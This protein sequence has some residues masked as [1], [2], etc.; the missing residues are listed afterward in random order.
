MEN[1]GKM[2]PSLATKMVAA[3][4][5]DTLQAGGDNFKQLRDFVRRTAG[6]R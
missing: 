3:T 5:S 2:P 4:G 6:L 1:C